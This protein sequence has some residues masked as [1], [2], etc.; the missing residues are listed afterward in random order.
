MLRLKRILLS[1]AVTAMTLCNAGAAVHTY[2]LQFDEFHELKVV[3]GINV[4]YICDKEKAGLIEFEADSTIASTVMFNPGK[5]KLSISLATRDTVYT[6]LPTVRVYSSFLSSVKNEGD[7]TVR[8]IAPAPCPEFQATLIGNGR[9]IVRDLEATEV[10]AKVTAGH[11]T[12]ILSGSV[13]VAKL[14]TLGGASDIQADAL[15]SKECSA[16][17]TGTG[18]ITCW[19]TDKLSYGGAG[20]GKIS[21]RGHPELSKKFI[22][23]VKLIALD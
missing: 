15:Q 8:V 17:V 23:K 12:I 18:A 7:S 19:A 1:A 2:H 22:T 6:N 4:D 11:G 3:D 10:K 5:G 16:T 21:Y 20:S 13:T 9:L 14:S